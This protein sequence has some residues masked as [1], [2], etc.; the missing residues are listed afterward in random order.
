MSNLIRHKPL[1]LR[2]A[3]V[4]LFAIVCVVGCALFG[5]GGEG[6]WARSE[7]Y[8][9]SAPASWKKREPVDSDKAYQL[10]SGSIATVT[11]SCNRHPGA[12]LP[13]LTKHLLFGT[14]NV[15]MQ[16]QESFPVDGAE[17][18]LSKLTATMD[19]AK[20]FMNIV[21]ARKEECVFDFSLMSPKPLQAGDESDFLGFVRSYRSGRP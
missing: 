14:R 13:L 12:T 7:H 1:P 16:K 9:V 15:D 20:F 5:G 17:G 6:N 11:S 19:G 18:L 2:T 10:P 21:V 3:L 4:C 8:V